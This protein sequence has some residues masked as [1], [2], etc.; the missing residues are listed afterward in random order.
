MNLLCCGLAALCGLSTEWNEVE[1]SKGGRSE[2]FQFKIK[3]I[4]IFNWGMSAVSPGCLFL[5][6]SFIHFFHFFAKLKKLKRNWICWMKREQPPFLQ[7]NSINSNSSQSKAGL[8][9]PAAFDGWDWIDEFNGAVFSPREVFSFHNW[10]NLFIPQT[11]FK[12]FTIIP[13]N[14]FPWAAQAVN[15][16]NNPIFPL[17]REDWNCFWFVEWPAA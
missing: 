10:S 15:N 17:G 5:S 4:F 8:T 11:P 2:P 9:A 7:L 3:I 1:W 13:F 16:Q 6:F 14:T 12:I